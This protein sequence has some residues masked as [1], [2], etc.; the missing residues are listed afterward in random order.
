MQDCVIWNGS[1]HRGYA[2]FFVYESGR[3][4]R[5]KAHREAWRLLVGPLP[6]GPLHHLCEVKDCVNVFHL[7]P[8]TPAQHNTIH[9]PGPPEVCAR[10]GASDWEQNGPH[11]R[12]RP[13]RNARRR[14]RRKLS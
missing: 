4:R 14:E 8:V 11:R 10:C 9:A 2:V 6:E 5:V 12:C 7:S 13:C 3:R 1:L